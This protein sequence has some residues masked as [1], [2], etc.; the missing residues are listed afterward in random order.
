MNK[1][2]PSLCVFSLLSLSSCSKTPLPMPPPHLVS[3]VNPRVMNVPLY[4]DY[5]GHMSAKVSVTV[6]SQVSGELVAQYFT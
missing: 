5:I 6:K 4:V 3:A 1:L 2:L